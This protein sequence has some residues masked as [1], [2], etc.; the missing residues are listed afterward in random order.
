M[1]GV[2]ERIWAFV[3]V[4]GILAFSLLAG[5]G[6]QR[7]YEL[8]AACIAAGGIWNGSSTSGQCLPVAVPR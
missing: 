7:D 3:L 2:N 6:C 8:K 5:F 1:E 4:I